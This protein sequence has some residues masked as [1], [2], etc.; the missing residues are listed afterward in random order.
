MATAANLDPHTFW[1]LWALKEQPDTMLHDL[2]L[3]V[4]LAVPKA[5]FPIKEWEDYWNMDHV[6]KQGTPEALEW[7]LSGK[8]K[9]TKPVPPLLGFLLWAGDYILEFVHKGPND[10]VGFCV[11]MPPCP[12]Y[13][14]NS[15]GSPGYKGDWEVMPGS[16]KLKPCFHSEILSFEDALRALRTSAQ[17]YKKI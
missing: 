12:G 6:P 9:E 10:E 14:D 4:L 11:R 7:M 3:P 1:V 13:E 5:I 15:I 17:Y 8:W 2:P 16:S